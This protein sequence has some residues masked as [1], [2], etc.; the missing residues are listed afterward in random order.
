LV[1]AKDKEATAK[2]FANIMGLEYVGI[3]GV[4]GVVR[5]DDALFL[6][7]DEARTS[8]VHLAFHVTNDEF[9]GV[10]G[11]L[12][13]GSV[14][15]GARAGSSDG[16]EGEYNGGRRIYFDSPGGLNTELMTVATADVG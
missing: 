16:E 3:D 13:S 5:V 2:F 15:F 14:T 10:L 9:D 4:C 1:P 7:F 11:R 12:R 8:R 6:R